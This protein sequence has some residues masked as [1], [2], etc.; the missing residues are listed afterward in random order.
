M[1]HS[2]FPRDLH[3][4]RFHEP[5]YVMVDRLWGEVEFVGYLAYGQLF[6]AEEEDYFS[7][8]SV[9]KYLE[10]FGVAY[11]FTGFMESAYVDRCMSL[12]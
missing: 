7:S 8:A 5:L 11:C 6:G 12:Y 1:V 10:G 4:F 3:H 2:H 9:G